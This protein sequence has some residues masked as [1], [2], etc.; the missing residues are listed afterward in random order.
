MKKPNNVF[1]EH[2]DFYISNDYFKRFNLASSYEEC[3]QVLGEFKQG[4]EI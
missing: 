3:R 1:Y 4:L 2:T